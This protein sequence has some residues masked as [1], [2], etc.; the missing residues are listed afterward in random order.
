MSTQHDVWDLG[1]QD[2]RIYNNGDIYIIDD[3]SIADNPD[4]QKSLTCNNGVAIIDLSV[5]GDTTIN[6]AL[7]QNLTVINGTLTI[8]N[9]TDGG[10]NT[11]IVFVNDDS[12]V[13]TPTTG[14]QT[15]YFEMDDSG[16]ETDDLG[17]VVATL[18]DINVFYSTTVITKKPMRAVKVGIHWEIELLIGHTYQIIGVRDKE[19][20]LQMSITIT[21]DQKKAL[22]TYAAAA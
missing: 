6:Y 17:V 22:S 10:G 12:D 2:S 15:V 9:G 3:V 20:F 11:N 21:S 1:A 4:Y 5:I 16:L 13:T 7:V 18:Q 19:I 8:H 14:C